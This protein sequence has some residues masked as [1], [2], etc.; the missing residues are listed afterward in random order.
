MGI[1]IKDMEMPDGCFL[2][3]LSFM[4]FNGTENV[5]RCNVLKKLVSDD[6][7]KD[8]DCPLIKIP[9]HGRLIDADTL[10]KKYYCG[11]YFRH[12]LVTVP[13]TNILYHIDNAQTVIPTDKDGET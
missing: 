2:C 9:Q 8:P 6:G 3:I 11:E 7:S 4:Y 13:V 5:L 1:Y 12:D 10:R